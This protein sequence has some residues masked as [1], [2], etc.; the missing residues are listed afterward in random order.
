MIDHDL[1]ETTQSDR[2]EGGKDCCAPF[3]LDGK[4]VQIRPKGLQKIKSF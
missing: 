1:D 3:G 2:S 4:R